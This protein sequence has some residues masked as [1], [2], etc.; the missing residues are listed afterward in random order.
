MMYFTKHEFA[1]PCCGEVMIDPEMVS[2][3]DTARGLADIPFVITSGFRCKEHNESVGGSPTSSHLNGTAVDL[4]CTTGKDRYTI[5]N[6]LLSAGFNRIGVADTFIH[7]DYDQNKT[8]EVIWT[9]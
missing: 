4:A 7:V 8:P 9:Y 5:I 3:L 2:R 6:S 1:C